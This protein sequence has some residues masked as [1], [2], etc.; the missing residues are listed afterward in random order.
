ME[1]TVGEAGTGYS[2]NTS[3]LLSAGYQQTEQSRYIALTVP[4]LASMDPSIDGLTGGR[5]TATG[6][7]HILTNNSAGYT[8]QISASTS[9]AM[10]SMNA[11]SSGSFA[12]YSPAGV[13]PDY[14]WSVA[15]TGS[16]FGFSPSGVDVVTRYYNNGS[17]CNQP[18]GSNTF[19]KCWEGI[20][21]T[22][23]IISQSAVA[24]EASGTDTY[25]KFSAESGNAHIQPSGA[26]Q[27]SVIVIAYMN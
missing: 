27:A 24:N 13:A 21:T 16:A 2:S 23:M 22:A 7:I 18:S 6:T 9:P 1:D 10:K 12:D 25:I 20:S 4:D 15:S 17:S 8:L 5:A 3:Y 14:D 11:S 19:D 26:Y